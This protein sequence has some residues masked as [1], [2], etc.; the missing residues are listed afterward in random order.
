[1]YC[2]VINCLTE[3]WAVTYMLHITHALCRCLT[4]FVE[5]CLD[6]ASSFHFQ[7]VL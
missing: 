3:H 1:M 2:V 4:P 5:V 6:M 7:T